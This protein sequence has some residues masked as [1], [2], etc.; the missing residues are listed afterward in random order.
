MKIGNNMKIN[1][2]THGQS[3]NLSLRTQHKWRD[4]G[5]M[6]ANVE[7]YNGFTKTRHDL[8]GCIDILAIGNG[9]T[10]AIQTTSKG[11]MTSRIKKIE[12]SEALPRMLE[13]KWR[14]V[15]E[16]WYKQKNKW[17]CEEFEF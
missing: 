5:Y 7:K 6:T 1:K 3:M 2:G 11:N 9:E 4:E 8:F 17:R 10:V 16:G 12:D 14:V 15:V 13:S